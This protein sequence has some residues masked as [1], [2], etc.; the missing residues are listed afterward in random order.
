MA[1][2]RYVLKKEVIPEVAIFRI[3]E[4]PSRVLVT[5]TVKA[6]IQE[7]GIIGFRFFDIENPPPNEP[8][9]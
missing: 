3:P 8:I 4:K 1:V 7:S 2:R 9:A 5:P 6:R